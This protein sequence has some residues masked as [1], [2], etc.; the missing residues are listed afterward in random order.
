[1]DVEHLA[2]LACVTV[3]Q[4]DQGLENV[5]RPV[6]MH[7]RCP[8][9]TE[10]PRS[11]QTLE[12]HHVVRVVMGHD[13]RV[14][15]VGRRRAEEI[16]KARQGVVAEIEKDAV[17]VVLYDVSA[18]C[19]AGLRPGPQLPKAT[20]PRETMLDLISPWSCRATVLRLT[21]AV[22]PN[23][24]AVSPSLCVIGDAGSLRERCRCGRRTLET[25]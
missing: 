10:P 2:E 24:R 15:S 25:A 8:S 14:K 16:E 3:F 9:L 5:G 17:P 20:S 4:S 18:A 11:K 13:H 21:V 1:M 6:Q 23:S 22:Y 12:I 7:S 19:A